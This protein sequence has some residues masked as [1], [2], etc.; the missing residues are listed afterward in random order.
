MDRDAGRP[1]SP[2][3]KRGWEYEGNFSPAG[4]GRGSARRPWSIFDGTNTLTAGK[5][6][7]VR[8]HGKATRA[9]PQKSLN[10]YLRGEYGEKRN[11]INALIPSA[12]PRQRRQYDLVFQSFVL[13]NGG[14]DWE[15]LNSRMSFCRSCYPN[16]AAVRRYDLRWCLSTGNTGAFY[17]LCEKIRQKLYRAALPEGSPRIMW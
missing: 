8:V 4:Q 15:R 16:G 1:G 6:I 17:T 7:G 5:N 14:N 13:R 10:V 12:A 9:C 2:G 3:K 11:S